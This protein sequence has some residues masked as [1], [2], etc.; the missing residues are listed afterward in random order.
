M[1]QVHGGYGYIA[2]YPIEQLYRDERIQRIYEGTNEINRMLIP[3]IFMKKGVSTKT[4]KVMTRDITAGVFVDEKILIDKMKQV[5]LNFSDTALAISGEKISKEQEILL[6]LADM[7]IEIFALESSLLRADKVL[8]TT[9]ESKKE[10]YRAICKICAI[11]AKQQFVNA[12]EKCGV[13]L[14]E[15][16]SDDTNSNLIFTDISYDT[17]GLLSAKRFVA[18]AIRQAEKYIF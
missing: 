4:A 5:Y 10:L 16:E 15:S 13:Y 2:E 18:D 11:R 1:L 14:K 7:A 6:S 12:A 9:T 8:A 3:G 17:S